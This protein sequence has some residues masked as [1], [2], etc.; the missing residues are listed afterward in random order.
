MF[1]QARCR[2]H[3]AASIPERQLRAAARAGIGLSLEAPVERVVVLGLARRAHREA[4]HGGVGPVVGQRLDD[5]I[6]RAAVGT[7]GER[8]AMAAVGRV[9]DLREAVRAGGDVGQHN[10]GLGARL[11]AVPHLEASI[12]DWLEQRGLQALDV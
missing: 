8:V 4:P 9:G 11:V 2:Q 6:A 12:A 1:A 10:G 3:L 5:A 7:V